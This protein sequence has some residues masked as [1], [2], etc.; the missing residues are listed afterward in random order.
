MSFSKNTSAL[1]T[2]IILKLID[3][4]SA[5]FCK[6]QIFPKYC[7]ALALGAVC[8]SFSL[9]GLSA[10]ADV[11]PPL[12]AQIPF[13]VDDSEVSGL[14]QQQ[15][16][17]DAFSWQTFIAANWPRWSEGSADLSRV[18]GQGGDHPTVW[19]AWL[20]DYDIL[21]PPGETPPA[22]SAGPLPPP[23]NCRENSPDPLIRAGHV[24]KAPDLASAFI[25]P[26]GHGPLID[27]HRRYVR[28]QIS[29]NQAMYDYI[30]SNDL[31]SAEG[32]AE[33]GSIEFPEG[34]IPKKT[35]G[36]IS[37]KAAW[38]ILDSSESPARFHTSRVFVYDPKDPTDCRIE[39]VAL[40][41]LHFSH[42]TVGAPQWIWSTFEH[43]DNAPTKGVNSN[44]HYSFFDPHCPLA[45]CPL[46]THLLPPWDPGGEGMPT[47]VERVVPIASG[48]QALNVRYQALLRSVDPT[49][50]WANY[51][52]VGTQRPRQ[53]NSPGF[54][55]G[56]PWPTF[57]AN[58]TM[59]T[60]IQGEIPGTSS[61]C[62]G[63]HN[64]ATTQRGKPTDFSYLLAR[65]GG[66]QN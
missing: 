27:Q 15:Y 2:K 55:L 53:P 36:A 16:L 5:F 20:Q 25:E 34:S 44:Q 57:L 18:I 13:D 40:V 7:R 60:F 42:K 32:L 59:E 51:Q 6:D 26:D 1:F 28:Y 50:V 43:V 46:N 30:R 41:G 12:S 22:W 66:G 4:N 56:A 48:T 23:A 10:T 65:V 52:L 49:S 31:Y 3:Q 19:E 39:T 37:L 58:T 21:V 54:P 62:T 64:R 9:S 8:S 14:H 24:T 47:Q 38:K 29:V 35:V 61:S 63:C 17:F 33:A 11:L 45:E